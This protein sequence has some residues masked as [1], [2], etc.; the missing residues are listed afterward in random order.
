MTLARPE[1]VERIALYDAWVY[2][3]QLPT[4]F[5]WA[6]AGGLGEMMFRLFYHERPEDKMVLA[7]YDK[8]YVTQELIEHTRKMQNRPGTTAAHLAAVRG[9]RY[10]EVQHRYSEIDQPVLLLWGREDTVTTL[11]MGERLLRDLPN[12]DMIV[13]PRCGH[14]PMIEAYDASTEDLVDFLG[15][16]TLKAE[17]SR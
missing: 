11:D 16:T 3:E 9:Q 12:A 10:E 7:F 6:R 15:Q 14:F 8:D 2:A 13:Y 4:F 5:V 17:A 1:R